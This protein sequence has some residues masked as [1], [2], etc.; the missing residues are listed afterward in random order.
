M[1]LL[2]RQVLAVSLTAVALVAMELVPSGAWA[3][4]PPRSIASACPPGVRAAVFEDVPTDNVHSR[5]IDCILF[6]GV[7]YGAGDGRYLPAARVSR[8]QMASF[9]VR[10][11]QKSGGTLPNAAA[12]AF[13][14]DN[15]S[16]HQP[17]INR[18]AAAGILDGKGG[19]LYDPTG[20]VTR[21]Q[22]ASFI[23][24]AYEYRS[25]TTMASKAD[26]FA[27]DNGTTH[28]GNINKGAEV[29]ITSGFADGT[30]GDGRF[31]TRDQ[32]ASFLARILDLLVT[33]G[34]ASTRTAGYSVKVI[35]VLPNDGVDR[36]LGTNGAIDRSV[37]AAQ[38]WF[39]AQTGG[40]HFSID[41]GVTTFRLSESNAD[42][43]S[44]GPFV[45]DRLET[46]LEAAG[47]DDPRK[48][49]A[50]YY[51][52]T[53]T[54]ACGGAAWPPTLVGNVT[55][56]YLRGEPPGSPP[57]ADTALASSEDAPGYWEF[58][59]LHEVIHTLGLTAD[60]AP[61]HT[62]AGHTSD[63]PRDVMYAGE[64]PWEPSELDIGSDDYFRH[65]ISGCPD[66]ADSVFL[67]PMPTAATVPPG[68]P[69]EP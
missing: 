24:Q 32:M 60:C 25:A 49:Y 31:V 65:S 17:A 10:L 47:F 22:M 68:W 66:L 41:P 59:L 69:V 37:V 9:I 12:D 15:G 67:E 63:D 23:V 61:N 2:N 57:C 50:V 43:A 4:P 34:L 27:D 30:Y 28:E 13:T 16:I 55:A 18:L 38:R 54:V 45:R 33:S 14:D 39:E 53:S 40:S 44:S 6:W 48:I 42:L 36:Q 56:L 1:V 26:H 7:T 19:G 3:A 11:V 5:S 35:Y 62:L 8:E 52:G 21:G 29:G 58:S 64:L 20:A 51:D 46:S